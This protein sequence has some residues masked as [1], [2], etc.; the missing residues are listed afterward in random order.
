MWT[1]FSCVD[2][3]ESNYMLSFQLISVFCILFYTK[4]G[5]YFVLPHFCSSIFDNKYLLSVLWVN[6]WIQEQ[7]SYVIPSLV[8]LSLILLTETCKVCMSEFL[9]CWDNIPTKA[10]MFVGN[11]SLLN[12]KQWTDQLNY[13]E[14]LMIVVFNNNWNIDIN[15]MILDLNN[16]NVVQI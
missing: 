2:L 6:Q 4:L 9:I 14:H 13:T 3:F 15:S 11:E 16:T 1:T 12:S 5:L 7:I 10:S 8:H